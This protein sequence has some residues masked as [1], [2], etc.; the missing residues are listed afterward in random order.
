MMLKHIIRTVRARWGEALIAVGTAVLC[1]GLL[2]ALQSTIRKQYEELDR[3]YEETRI[4]CT[5]SN[6]KGTSTE[7]LNIPSGYLDFFDEK[8]LL[9]DDVTD[10]RCCAQASF[11][12]RPEDTAMEERIYLYLINTPSAVARFEVA[13]ITYLDGCDAGMYDGEETVG[14]ISSS[15]LPY[16][17][18]G[19]QMTLCLPPKCE[20]SVT[21][22][23]I[24]TC[25]SET[26]VL[27]LSLDAG[28]ELFGRNE[29]DFHISNISFTVADNRRL[30]E[31]KMALSDYFVP[32]NRYHTSSAR[33]GLIMD[34]AVLIDAV[35]V[36]ERS[37][38]LFRLFRTVMF[39]L[40]MGICLLVIFLL[41]R[42]RRPELAVMH[43]LGRGKGSLVLQLLVEYTLYYAVGA[44]P[45]I[46][47]GY[48]GA[49][50]SLIG[51]LGAWWMIGLLISAVAVSSGD[52]MK[53]LKGKE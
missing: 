29:R 2:T 39:L 34:D 49:R 15:L 22:R 7:N 33:F 50:V 51:A 52:V 28:R 18:D 1:L 42:R 43:S 36:V 53:I 41:I 37:I 44:L 13:P 32:A 46:F 21:F 17:S 35:T 23:V 3:V 27:Y 30:N 12:V 11:L 5:V 25:E 4:S 26:P 19:G 20:D 48:G 40:S 14:V 47:L 9:Y 24:G 31:T 16:V 10:F 45:M 38:A 6:A 8:G